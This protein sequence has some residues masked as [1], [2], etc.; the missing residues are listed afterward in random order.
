MNEQENNPQDRQLWKQLQ[1]ARTPEPSRTHAQIDP[2]DLAAYLDGTVKEST[3]QRIEAQM[4]QDPELLQTVAELRRL[5]SL[6]LIEPAPRVLRQAA[7]LVSES[8]ETRTA[9]H[10]VVRQS[11]RTVSRM[12]WATRWRMGS[13]WAAAAILVLA[14]CLIGY[15]LGHGTLELGQPGDS[16]STN[17]ALVD[18][19]DGSADWM[20][21]LNGSVA[22]GA[23]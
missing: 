1:T 8:A 3:A 18:W 19:Y 2:N 23:L 20:L 17:S 9:D 14:A 10:R 13:R 21:N 4:C 6:Q 16:D 11:N 5:R 7:A 12:L 15:T 22:G